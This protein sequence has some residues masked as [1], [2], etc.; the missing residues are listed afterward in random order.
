[1][2]YRDLVRKLHYTNDEKFN[3]V[4]VD[5]TS[6]QKEIF[7]YFLKDRKDNLIMTEP[8]INFGGKTYRTITATTSMDAFSPMK[9]EVEA[10]IAPN[11]EVDKTPK[12]PLTIT[13]VIFNP[14]A[15]IVFWSDNTKT[16]VKCDTNLEAYDPEKG[17]AMAISRKMLTDNKRDYYNVFKHWLKKWGKQKELIDE[18]DHAEKLAEYL[19]SVLC[20]EEVIE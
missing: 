14:P 6:E 7:D 17:I 1:M 12:A 10:Y 3:Y 5:W 4:D 11:Y 8:T 15:T 16:V 2:T 13:N 18:I 9:L 20:D 19:E